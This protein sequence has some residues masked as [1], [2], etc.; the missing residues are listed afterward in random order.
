MNDPI[1]VICSYRAKPGQDADAA[2]DRST[3]SLSGP[4]IGAE[5]ERIWGRFAEVC[6]FV[7]LAS[8][9]EA[10]KPFAHFLSVP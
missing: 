9:S 7:P 2:L 4:R 5:V 1:L 3:S 10:A 8:V 6:D